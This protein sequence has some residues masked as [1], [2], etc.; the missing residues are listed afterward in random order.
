MV[1]VAGNR[2]LLFS[3]SGWTFAEA[4]RG[5][6][7]GA[8]RGGAYCRDVRL[9]RL[10]GVS[11]FSGSGESV[12]FLG[13]PT[14]VRERWI[15]S[16]REAGVQRVAP[17]AAKRSRG[18]SGVFAGRARRAGDSRNSRK[19][20]IRAAMSFER[21]ITVAQSYTN[22]L[23]RIVFATSGTSYRFQARI[24]VTL[25]AVARFA[26]SHCGESTVNPRLRFAAPGATRWSPASRA[27][28]ARRLFK[29]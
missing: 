14:V 16:A 24:L 29:M 20:S 26:G 28:T 12:A 6:V 2:A 8:P 25:D 22:L 3:D 15:L 4:A 21:R 23:Y 9:G 7:S 13:V 11:T 27:E 18:L 1:T 10:P 17:G 5:A 19:E